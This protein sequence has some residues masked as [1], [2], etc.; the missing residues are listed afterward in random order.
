MFELGRIGERR[1]DIAYGNPVLCVFGFSH[2]K[3]GD[4]MSWLL[5]CGYPSDVL[6]SY[7]EM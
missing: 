5:G 3:P 2:G 4:G 1:L 6:L 7:H